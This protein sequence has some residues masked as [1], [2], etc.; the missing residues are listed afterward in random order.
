MSNEISQLQTRQRDERAC[1][2]RIQGQ[3]E[4]SR[5]VV[6]TSSVTLS[7]EDN[8]AM[9]DTT[10]NLAF[11]AISQRTNQPIQNMANPVSTVRHNVFRGLGED[12]DVHINRF[13]TVAQANNQAADADKLRVFPATLDGYACDWYSL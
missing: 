11:I 8:Q 2:R 10:P 6:A 9:I 3:S 5:S 4:Q 7:S 12:P 1:K 13:N